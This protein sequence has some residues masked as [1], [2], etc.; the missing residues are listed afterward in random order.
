MSAQLA[1][2][3]VSPL[4]LVRFVSGKTTAPTPGQAPAWKWFGWTAVAPPGLGWVMLTETRVVFP[5]GVIVTE[6]AWVA[7]RPGPNWR[8]SGVCADA[9]A[10]VA[11]RA[12][13]ASATDSFRMR[14]L[15]PSGL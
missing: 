13:T 6:P 3:V 1:L 2:I 14:A 8:V 11:T 12:P 5:C 7:S 9:I 15:S 4:P 10:V